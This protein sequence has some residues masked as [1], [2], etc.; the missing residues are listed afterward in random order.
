ML[1]KTKK[2]IS[3]ILAVLMVVTLA[4]PAFG[5][6]EEYPTIYVTG[7]QTNK[8][9]NT[10]NEWVSDFDIDLGAVLE[11]YGIDLVSE[12]LVGMISDNYEKWAKDFHDVFVS[13]Y[14]KSALDKNGEATNG[15]HP[16]H[17]SSTVDVAKKTSGF[18]AWDYRFWFDWR[19]SPLVTGEELEAY[20][21]RVIEATGA[22]KVNLVGRCYG[23]NVIAAYVQ[24][25]KDHA[26]A[27]VD[28]IAY[29]A[30]S[31]EGI[32]FMTALYTGEIYL[33]DEALD[34][35]ASWYIENENL[36]EDDAM[37]SFVMTLVELFNQAKVLGFTAEKLDLL[38]DR[39]K[40]DLLPSLLRD[41]FASWPSYWA[42]VT[43]GNLEKA[44]SFIYG[45]VEEEYA[46]MISKIR[47]YYNTVQ[48]NHTSTLKEMMGKGVRYNVFVKYNFPEYPIYKGA[49][50]QSDGDTPVPRQ[51]FGATAA[52]YGKVLS[53][54]YI[55]TISEENLKY[56]SPDHKIDASTGLLPENTWY[57][58]NLHHNHWAAIEGIF[59]V[60]MNNDYNVSSQSKYPQFMDNNNNMAEVTPDEDY[61]KPEDNTL[62]SLFRFLTA[63]FNL[64]T[65]VFK[66][67]ISFK[68]MFSSLSK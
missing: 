3:V 13:I 45:G 12:F 17:H 40:G 21:D 41:T 67:E 1:K 8:I 50:I 4:T 31:I 52:N 42:M 54:D 62:I 20:I 22:K 39:I 32:D 27:Y 51:A 2:L 46:G 55:A 30:P 25:N 68:E 18:G 38:I 66:G 59:L 64:L 28:D 63:F 24:A 23:A 44:I 5:A 35:F 57:V 19:L 49:A 53:E 58:K 65:K 48:V 37:A 33:D 47:E 34:N 26:E 7:A 6:Y 43:E 36:I 29:L 14:E 11:E 56:L 60:I 61:E 10:D 16:E 15:T 9:Y